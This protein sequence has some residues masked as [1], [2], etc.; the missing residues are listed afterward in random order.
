LKLRQFEQTSTHTHIC[1]YAF[2]SAAYVHGKT[3]EL[4]R[5][6]LKIAENSPTSPKLQAYSLWFMRGILTI[7]ST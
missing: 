5:K 6:Q 7:I 1:M 3:Q 4:T 2:I